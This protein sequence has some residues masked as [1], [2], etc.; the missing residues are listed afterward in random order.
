MSPQENTFKWDTPHGPKD[1]V[2]VAILNQARDLSIVRD[3]QWYRI[4]VSSADKWLRRRWPPQWIAFYQ[5]K[6]FGAEAF[7]IHYCARVLGIRQVFRWELFPDERSHAKSA[8]RYH[9]MMLGPLQRLPFPIRSRRWRRIVF[10]STTWQKFSHAREINELYDESPLEDLLWAQIKRVNLTAERQEFITANGTDYALDFAFYCATGNL[11][12]ETDGDTWHTDPTRIAADN[13]RDNDLETGGWK[14]LRFNSWH[15]REQMTDYCVPT[16]VENVR[17]LGGLAEN[18]V[19]P[20]DIQPDP[21]S[22]SQLSLFD[23]D[24]S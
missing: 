18:R 7:A 12:V 6:I 22:P 21:A 1:E 11:D 24:S 20:R 19:V 23:G 14:L 2:L 5:T 4:P 10:I 13:R 9:Q 15:L 16:I 8:E 3:Q 17:R